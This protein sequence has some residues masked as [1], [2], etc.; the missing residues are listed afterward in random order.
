MP[1]HF[2]DRLAGRVA[3]EELHG[4]A[5]AEA[6]PAEPVRRDPHR[7]E[8]MCRQ[9]QEDVALDPGAEVGR[10][11]QALVLPLAVYRQAVDRETAVVQRLGEGP[12]VG[13]PCGEFVRPPADMPLR[14]GRPEA[15]GELGKSSRLHCQQP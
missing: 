2:R 4:A 13:G 12:D 3:V 7:G 6:V 10:P 1:E 9:G 8:G 11:V 15:C 14:Q 5:A